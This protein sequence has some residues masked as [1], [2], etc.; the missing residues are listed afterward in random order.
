MDEIRDVIII[1]SGPAGLSAAIYAQR[2][3]LNTLT[4]E[5]A[6]MSGGQAAT[7]YEVDN[8]PGLPGIGGFDLGQ[9]MRAHADQLGAEFI[10]EK[11]LSIEAIGKTKIVK[12]EV[13]SYKAKTV[14][15]ATGATYAKLNIPGEEK[16]TGMGVSFC[17]T[18]DGAFYKNKTVAVVGGGNV[19]IEDAIFLARICE[20]VYVVH[21]RDELRGAKGL[22]EV[23]F[24]INNVE[25]LWDCEVKSIIGESQVENMLVI[26]N[27]TKAETIVA[28]SGIF[29]AVGIQPFTELLVGQ[30]EVDDGAYIIADESGTTSV[31]GVFV[32]GDARQKQLRQIITAASD[33][34]NAITSIEKYLIEY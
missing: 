17:A 9:K 3:K 28:I 11:V 7:T 23:L 10:N 22:Q 24:K 19:A 15:L 26:N 25:I 31:P 27:K 32:A 16:F 12:T 1:G 8:Y 13:A 18:C 14:L 30:V 2:A 21:R 34:A 5:M 29:I 20:K 4:F 33:G 6:G